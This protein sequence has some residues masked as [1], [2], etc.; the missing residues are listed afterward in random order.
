MARCGK[1]WS[2]LKKKKKV[3][4]FYGMLYDELSTVLKSS[5]WYVTV[6]SVDQL[7]EVGVMTEGFLW[8]GSIYF[9][10]TPCACTV[11]TLAVKF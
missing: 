1:N 8:G 5:A 2:M 10:L 11:G 4:V 7:G 3:S 9:R 6:D